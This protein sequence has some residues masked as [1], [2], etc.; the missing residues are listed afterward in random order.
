MSDR[1]IVD[2]G[3]VVTAGGVASAL[4]LGLYLVEKFWGA[5]ARVK[6]AAQ[7]EYRAYSAT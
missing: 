3:Q 4:D 7:M 5:D 2:E 6:I 1:R